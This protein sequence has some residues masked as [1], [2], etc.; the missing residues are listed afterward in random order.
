M[1]AIKDTTSYLTFRFGNRKFH[2]YPG[3]EKGFS[4][5]WKIQACRKDGRTLESRIRV[6]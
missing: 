5:M 2:D 1:D 3:K 6:I 4:G